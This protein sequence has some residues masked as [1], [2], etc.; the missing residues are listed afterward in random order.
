MTRRTMLTV[1][2]LLSVLLFTLH[3]ADDVVRGNE[4]GTFI[5]LPTFPICVLWL[6]GALLL[7]GRRWGYAIMLLGGLLG[8]IVPL[9]HIRG[10]GLGVAGSVAASDGALFY[11][12]TLTAL[13]VT[14]SFAVVLAIGALIKP[15]WAET[16]A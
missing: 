13:G 2:T 5:N 10:K 8:M 15:A 9:A 14:A 16:I 3:F 12:W 1:F 7:N 4:P 11:I 6:A